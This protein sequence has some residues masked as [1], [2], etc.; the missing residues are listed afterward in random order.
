MK[1]NFTLKATE[2]VKNPVVR[3]S[4]WDCTGAGSKWICHKGYHG[5]LKII[6]LESWDKRLKAA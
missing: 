5:K 6:A 1:R 2:Q 3:P 4:P